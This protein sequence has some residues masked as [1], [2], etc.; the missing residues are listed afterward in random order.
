M[1]SGNLDRVRAGVLERI[2]RSER[3]YRA[4][5]WS[6]VALE[7]AFLLGFLFL[8]DFRNRTHMLLLLATVAVY[9][10]LALGLVA[11]GAHVSRCTER[12]LR[13]IEAARMEERPAR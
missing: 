13:A 5:F 3:N 10:I 6:A 4:A 9:T 12:V 2:E 7:G 11:L 1:S 8:A